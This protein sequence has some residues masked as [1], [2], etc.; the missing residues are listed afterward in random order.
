MYTSLLKRNWMSARHKKFVSGTED[1]AVRK[2]QLPERDP[3]TN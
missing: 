1:W 3:I 2:G